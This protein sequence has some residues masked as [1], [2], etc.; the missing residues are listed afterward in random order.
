M[1][2]SQ[3]VKDRSG[4]HYIIRLR[5]QGHLN[6]SV[7]S[8]KF[9]NTQV[10]YQFVTNLQA[11]FG[12]WQNI[13]SSNSFFNLQRWQASHPSLPIEHYAAEVLVQ[14]FVEVYKTLSPSQVNQN[15]SKNRFKDD[16]GRTLYFQ[17]ASSLLLSNNAELKTIHNENEAS[18]LIETLDLPP[19]ALQELQSTLNLAPSVQGMGSYSSNAQLVDALVSGEVVITIEHEHKP[20][21]VVEYIEEVGRIFVNEGPPVNDYLSFTLMN[22]NGEPLPGSVVKLADNNGASIQA[23]ANG[24]GFVKIRQSS[25]QPFTEGTIKFFKDEE[26]ETPYFEGDFAVEDQFPD[27]DTTEGIQARCNNL[28]Y[29]AGTVDGVQGKK[30]EEAIK[31]LQERYELE[32]DAIAEKI[33]KGQMQTLLPI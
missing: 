9:H 10:S 4:Q 22:G 26:A 28:G 3:I 19:K 18:Q 12:L 2:T 31:A 14:G 32:T 1:F 29:D 23:V 15:R 24:S 27:I 6:L 21:A 11:P 7:K 33:T 16:A 20:Q 25:K 30:T 17:P 5:N 13:A 8:E